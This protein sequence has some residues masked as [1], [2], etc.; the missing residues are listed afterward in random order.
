MNRGPAQLFAV[1]GLDRRPER[2]RGANMLATYP[3][4]PER[5]PRRRQFGSQHAGR[6]AVATTVYHSG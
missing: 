5:S 2:G 6:P 3:V 1:W 4:R